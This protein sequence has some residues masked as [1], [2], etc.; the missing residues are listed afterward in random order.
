MTRLFCRGATA[1][2]LALLALLALAPMALADAIASQGPLTLSSKQTWVAA[3]GVLVPLIT[4]VVNNIG[5][6]VSEP[7]KG[8]VTVLVS[9]LA[10][11]LYTAL[12]TSSFGWNAAT[13][14]M[15][16]TSVVASLAA[17]HMLW[18]PSGISTVFGAGA[19]RP[20]RRLA[21]V[22]DSAAPEPPAK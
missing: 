16:L 17:H 1:L 6:W 10:G 19:N 4:Y 12:A 2:V 11:G 20:H 9:A 3:I 7:V 21:W 13:V 8:F 5:P 14:Q 22:S 15:V 18:K